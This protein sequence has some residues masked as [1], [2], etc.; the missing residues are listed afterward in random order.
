MLLLAIF[1]F[2]I[3]RRRSQRNPSRHHNV[4]SRD[5]DRTIF[6][7]HS[8]HHDRCMTNSPQGGDFIIPLTV[9]ALSKHGPHMEH[10]RL[11]RD[12]D[13]DVTRVQTNGQSKVLSEVP[14]LSPQT[15]PTL[16]EHQA[17]E[18][19]ENR[20]QGLQR[21]IDVLRNEVNEWWRALGGHYEQSSSGI[22]TILP[23]YEDVIR[24][25]R[26]DVILESSS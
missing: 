12:G 25:R 24:L 11:R 7:H 15:S 1:I 13:S 2:G 6:G 9:E 18:D 4:P 23:S 8:Y 20:E 22:S 26:D 3:K 5:S 17:G 16:I 19:R 10:I 14:P 21:E